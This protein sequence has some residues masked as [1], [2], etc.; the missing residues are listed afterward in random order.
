MPTVQEIV[1]KINIKFPS[2]ATDDQI[3]DMMDTYQKRLFRKYKIPTSV[4]YDIIADTYAYNVGIKPKLIFEVL[5]D[6]ERYPKRQ[7]VGHSSDTS[8]YFTFIDDFLWIYPTPT[9]DGTLAIY[10]YDSPTTL[11]SSS[12][13]A[14]PHLDSD[15]HDLLVYGP[16]F[17]LAENKQRYDVASGFS[18][19]YKELESE[20][21]E[22]FQ[23]T[24]EVE[25]ILSESG[26]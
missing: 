14:T 22:L 9:A 24:P 13:S 12:M 19:Q 25:T 5:V 6:G 23:I 4:T 3:V 20:L 21:A 11:T 16:C 10:Y 17:E 2:G 26:W 7:L 15:F 1:D 18:L 8:Q